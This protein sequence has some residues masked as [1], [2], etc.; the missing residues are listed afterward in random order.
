MLY[1]FSIVQFLNLFT[2]K[3]YQVY[4]N[5]RHDQNQQKQQTIEPISFGT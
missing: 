5:T 2:N 1:N 4:E 3:N